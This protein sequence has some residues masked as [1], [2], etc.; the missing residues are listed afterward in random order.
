MTAGAAETYSD[1]DEYFG[2][3]EYSAGAPGKFRV[4]AERRPDQRN[5]KIDV[6]DPF[7]E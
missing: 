5:I 6:C 4:H 2:D 3:F 7:N 1:A